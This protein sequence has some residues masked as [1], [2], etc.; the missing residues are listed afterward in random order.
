[1]KEF[2]ML[3]CFGKK[4]DTVPQI[5]YLPF[6]FIV[7][8]LLELYLTQLL[9][10]V[11]G[12]GLLK[13]GALMFQLPVCLPQQWLSLPGSPPSLRINFRKAVR[14]GKLPDPGGGGDLS[15]REGLVS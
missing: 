3:L 5:L 15:Q 4:F 11:L 8:P 2:K 7:I 9:K 14:A 1:M 6:L 10:H 13:M 12:R